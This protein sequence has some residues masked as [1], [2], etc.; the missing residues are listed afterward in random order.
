M[1][2]KDTMICSN[3]KACSGPCA[4]GK[5]HEFNKGCNLPCV[6]EHMC[7]CVPTLSTDWEPPSDKPPEKLPLRKLLIKARPEATQ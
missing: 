5:P 1:H 6:Q 3:W 2:L 7:R 4:S